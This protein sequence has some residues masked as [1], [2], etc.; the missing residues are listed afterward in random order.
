M[1]TLLEQLRAEHEA[2]FIGPLLAD[3]LARVASATART[4]PTSYTPA[5]VWNAEAIADALQDWTAERLVGRRDLARL[6]GGARSVPALRAGLTRSFSQHLTNGRQATSSTNLF[7]RMVKMLRDD[8]RFEPVGNAPKPQE[9]LWTLRNGHREPSTLDLRTRLKVAAELSDDDLGVVRY[10][11]LSLKSSPI[12]REDGLRRFLERLLGGVG[13]LTPAD[14]MEIMRRRFALVDPERVELVDDLDAPQ[15]EVHD[16]V[17]EDEIV[18]SVVARLGQQRADVLAALVEH[19][20]VKLAAKALD[21][22][23]SVIENAYADLKQMV[24]AEA[25]E[26]DEVDYVCGLAL[27]SLFGETE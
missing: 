20:D 12:L 21:I 15:P 23:T 18:R 17:A 4:Y 19:E 5:G 6:I 22:D 3:L 13:P 9:E 2:M 14:I 8:P 16:R 26:P 7:K 1:S 10:K 25:V 27:E 24:I 11:A